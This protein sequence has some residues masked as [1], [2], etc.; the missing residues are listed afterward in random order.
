MENVLPK[1]TVDTERVSELDIECKKILSS[2][3]LNPVEKV[4]GVDQLIKPNFIVKAGRVIDAS[5]SENTADTKA[6]PTNPNLKTYSLAREENQIL[7][8]E[9]ADEIRDIIRESAWG[10]S[11]PISLKEALDSPEM[12]NEE[13]WELLESFID[14]DRDYKW[15]YINLVQ[16]NLKNN[17]TSDG[18][19][20]W[21]SPQHFRMAAII[22]T[23][24]SEVNDFDIDLAK[25][26]YKNTNQ[27]P[28]AI[29]NSV[30][31]LRHS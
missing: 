17:K 29:S 15:N 8:T 3:E 10:G 4:R 19:S 18:K 24:D 20:F 27:I 14:H 2:S 21:L 16:F 31:T 5:E 1:Q 7:L 26:L 13:T 9:L 25:S 28:Q 22:D 6:D 23:V 11:E 12:F 30:S